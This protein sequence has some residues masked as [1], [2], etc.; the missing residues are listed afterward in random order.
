MTLSLPTTA[1]SVGTVLTILGTFSYGL[2]SFIILYYP[3]YYPLLSFIYI[4]LL[5]SLYPEIL[6]NRDTH[7][8]I[9]CSAKKNFSFILFD[10]FLTLIS[11]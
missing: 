7:I 5:F 10:I 3:S 11:T 2:I 4:P 8:L 1:S 9:S 6:W